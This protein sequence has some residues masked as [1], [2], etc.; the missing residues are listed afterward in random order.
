MGSSASEQRYVKKPNGYLFLETI[1]N[2]KIE[3]Q[4]KE[5]CKSSMPY[6]KLILF[7]S[8]E[9]SNVVF[10]LHCNREKN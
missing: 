1:S 3:D 10:L 4:Y 9:I 8:L 2:E 6:S 5:K 7:H